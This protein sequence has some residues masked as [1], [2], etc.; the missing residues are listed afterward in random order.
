MICS[1]AEILAREGLAELPIRRCHVPG[2]G[3]ASVTAF[4]SEGNGLAHQISVGLPILPPVTCHAHPAC[5]RSLY[6]HAHDIPCARD[7]GDQN[8]VEVTEAI[9]CESDSTPLSAWHPAILQ[10]FKIQ[11][12]YMIP[13]FL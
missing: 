7:V 12:Y 9:D 3:G 13:I 8:Q 6:A 5:F 4:D 1:D 10:K 11:K 2:S